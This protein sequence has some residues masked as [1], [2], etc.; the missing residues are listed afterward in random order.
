MYF[1]NFIAL[2]FAGAAGAAALNAQ[3]E[4]PPP[5]MTLDELVREVLQNNPERAFYQAEIAAAKGALQTAAAWPNPELSGDLGVKRAHEPGGGLAGEGAAWSAALMQPF[6]WPGRLELRKAIA[7]KQ[8]E[9]AELGLARFEAALAAKARS[10]GYQ[11]IADRQRARVARQ[12]AAR[13]AE[14]A[15]V[16]VQRDPAGVTPL[17]ETRIIEA[18]VAVQR[19]EAARAVKAAE[20]ARLELNQLRGSPYGSAVNL[21]PASIELPKLPPLEHLLAAAATNNFELRMRAAELEQQGFEVELAKNERWPSISAGPF[22][23]Q[24]RGGGKEQIIGLGV[25]VPVP[26]WNHNEGAITAAEARREQARTALFLAQREVEREIRLHAAGYELERSAIERNRPG[27]L[28]E[29][30][31]AAELADRHYRLGA[32]PVS[33]YIEAQ[34]QYAAALEAILAARAEALG[35]IQQLELLTGLNLLRPQTGGEG[36]GE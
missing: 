3:E 21:A 15:S 1:R 5:P 18:N 10:L 32:V 13:G 2:V 24:E 6:E 19:Q 26:L 23:S 4:N 30:E 20:A 12:V 33:T 36:D 16:L 14:L 7:N 34:T 29:L 22:Y 31:S 35:H 8:I 28:A 11:L 17:I 25:S 9:L 27:I